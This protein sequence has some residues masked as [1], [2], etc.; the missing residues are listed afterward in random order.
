[1]LGPSTDL[2]EREIIEALERW[3]KEGAKSRD[4][5]TVCPHPGGS[6]AHYMHS[7]GWLQR[8]LQLALCRADAGYRA[9][10]I[11]GGRVKESDL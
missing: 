11:N 7:Q 9:S 3:S 10:Q 6:L 5:L 4:D 8:D 1:M 2:A